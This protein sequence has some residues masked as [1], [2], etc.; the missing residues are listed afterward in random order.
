[1]IRSDEIRRTKKTINLTLDGIHLRFAPDIMTEF[2][3]SLSEPRLRWTELKRLALVGLNRVAWQGSPGQAPEA[4]LLQAAARQTLARR[5]GW[6]PALLPDDVAD[7]VAAAED[8]RPW[9]DAAAS[10]LLE[11]LLGGRHPAMLTEWLT[12]AVAQGQLVRPIYLPRLLTL[13]LQ[14]ELSPALLWQATGARGAW[15]A[16]QHP[17]WRALLPVEASAWETGTRP[18]RLRYLVALRQHDPDAARELLLPFTE[19]SAFRDLAALLPALQT[20]LSPADL[21]LLDS[22][23]N[24]G[25]KEVR[26]VA[27]PL[28][29]QLADSQ[30]VQQAVLRSSRWVTLDGDDLL[31]QLPEKA[32]SVW[33]ADYQP[34]PPQ[35]G[36]DFDQWSLQ[37]GQRARWLLRELSLV[38]PA[39]WVE[40]L[41]ERPEKLLRRLPY[42]PWGM[43][44]LRGWLLAALN[45][46]DQVWGQAIFRLLLYPKH[47]PVLRGEASYARWLPPGLRSPLMSL[48]PEDARDQL[49]AA[50]MPYVELTAP[51]M[52]FWLLLHSASPVGV[53]VAKAFAAKLFSLLQA[54]E[55]QVSAELRQF[56]QA[57]TGVA[58]VLPA[59]YFQELLGTWALNPA[60]PQ[61]YD[62]QLEGVIQL[63]AFRNRMRR[64]LLE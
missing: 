17:T 23:T 44:L 28:L 38:P 13:A 24:H 46:G 29:A 6:Q 25:R 8:E 59:P 63:M 35:A 7:P 19:K 12:L 15:L 50:A 5:A 2:S 42:H 54:G 60:Y 9:A 27:L 41:G 52:P 32:D 37:V 58:M 49:L 26:S 39:H 31:V 11:A 62:P 33:L 21:P 10:E 40:V 47:D 3:S 1:V 56:V 64:T 34:Q 16:A 57:M 61:W 18:E 48:L 22:L 51:P 4:E 55:R 36:A 30:L 45:H 20:A 14:V 43:V 53:P